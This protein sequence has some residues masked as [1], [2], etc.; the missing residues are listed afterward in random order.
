MRRGGQAHPPVRGRP[1]RAQG[2]PIFT[3][4]IKDSHFSPLSMQTLASGGGKF[5][6]GTGVQLPQILTGIA[7]SLSGRYLV[8]YRSPVSPGKPISVSA[9]VAGSPG[10]VDVS[11]VAPAPPPVAAKPAARAAPTGPN[12]TATQVL[13]ALPSFAQAT[14]PP[15]PSA[16]RH[17]GALRS[18][19]LWWPAFARC[20]SALPWQSC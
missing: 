15:A 3:V 19:S 11:Y 9:Q 1:A 16:P 5:V 13:T 17:S 14:A 18:A 6:T 8:R 4:G 20:S 2:V 12:L 10:T 7:A